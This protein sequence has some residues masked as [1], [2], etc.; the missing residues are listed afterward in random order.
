MRWNWKCSLKLQYFVVDVASASVILISTLW[1]RMFWHIFDSTDSHFGNERKDSHGTLSMFM[2]LCGLVKALT[3]QKLGV[4]M[5]VKLSKNEHHR[6]ILWCCKMEIGYWNGVGES[7]CQ[8]SSHHNGHLTE[9]KHQENEKD[10]ETFKKKDNI[11]YLS[12]IELYK[13]QYIECHIME[14]KHQ[15]VWQSFFS[16]FFQIHIFIWILSNQMIH[17]VFSWVAVL[18]L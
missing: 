7:I 18:W 12:R 9:L 8:P 3:F 1:C 5:N 10:H 13:S 16:I 4:K 11:I 15:F 17:T 6:F 14:K 2:F